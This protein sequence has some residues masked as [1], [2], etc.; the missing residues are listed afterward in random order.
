MRKV[1]VI[2]HV[3]EDVVLKLDGELLIG[4]MHFPTELIY[5]C[6]GST[7]NIAIA[8][9]SGPIET[10]F[11]TYLGNDDAAK[12]VEPVLQS[13]NFNP[14]LITRGDEA[15]PRCLVVVD[16]F[17]ERTLMLLSERIKGHGGITFKNSGIKSGDIVVFTHWNEEWRAE[18]NYAR[19]QGCT[20]V[21]GLGALIANPK[22]SADVVIGSISDI[23]GELPFEDYLDRFPLIVVTRGISGSTLYSK[24]GRVHQDALPV[25]T[26]DTTGAG[27]AFLAG[28]LTG[29][30]LGITPGKILLEIGARWASLMVTIDASIPPNFYEIEGI[31]ELIASALSESK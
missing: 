12:F 23:P 24:A 1:W 29:Y 7:S 8:V 18:I 2:G 3:A 20:I 16:E 4:K 5:R 25:K 6:G 28:F 10:G 17:G 9:A 30:A 15:T 19:E 31:Q 22:V 21:I 14:L 27:D 26:I 11:I 13:S